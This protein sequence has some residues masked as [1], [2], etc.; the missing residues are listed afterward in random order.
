MY[1]RN[2]GTR[3]A[4]TTR[5]SL[6]SYELPCSISAV[7]ICMC[8]LCIL[9]RCLYLL[10]CSYLLAVHLLYRLRSA[11]QLSWAS[12]YFFSSSQSSAGCLLAVPSAMFPL[13]F[14]RTCSSSS[15]SYYTPWRILKSICPRVGCSLIIRD[16]GSIL[17]HVHS[18]LRTY[19][20]KPF[21][22][23]RVSSRKQADCEGVS[24]RLDDLNHGPHHT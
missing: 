13:Q 21:R 11:R 16:P 10:R 3:P 19:T 4:T 12:P 24:F 15:R 9:A 1:P 22:R 5:L 7:S 8:V 2:K 20:H 6:L 17:A 23:G 18:T 14:S